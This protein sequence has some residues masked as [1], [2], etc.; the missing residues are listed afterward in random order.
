MKW[1][2]L[3][4]FYGFIFTFHFHCLWNRCLKYERPHNNDSLLS[5]VILKLYLKRFLSICWLYLK[6]WGKNRL[7]TPRILKTLSMN[8]SK[9]KNLEGPSTAKFK[10]YSSTFYV[11]P[12]YRPSMLRLNSNFKCPF[13][14]ATIKKRPENAPNHQFQT[15]G[16][17]FHSSLL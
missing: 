5:Y 3:S 6:P 1:M 2:L 10:T 17:K 12:S 13:L 16:P 4:R 7:I 15:N 14:P 11:T 9:R 8:P